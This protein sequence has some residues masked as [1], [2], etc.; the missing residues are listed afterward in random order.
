MNI[1]D[2]WLREV[3][4]FNITFKIVYL[5]VV[6]GLTILVD[7]IFLGIVKDFPA[8]YI[9]YSFFFLFFLIWIYRIMLSD[10]RADKKNAVMKKEKR[11]FLV[12]TFTDILI[13]NFWFLDAEFSFMNLLIAMFSCSLIL[14]LIFLLLDKYILNN[15]EVRIYFRLLVIIILINIILLYSYNL[16]KLKP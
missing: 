12:V 16:T 5:S 2:Y 13:L 15:S 1:I 9:S 4:E 3:A 7:L 14:W 10:L 6:T 8:E 11:Y